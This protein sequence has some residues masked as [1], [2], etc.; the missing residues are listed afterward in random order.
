MSFS[1]ISSRML[2]STSAAA[3]TTLVT[4]PRL[5]RSSAV[6]AAAAASRVTLRSYS[7][8][9]GGKYLHSTYLQSHYY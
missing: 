5:A 4:R 7:D 3:A 9:K 1:A 6:F 8:A 2:R